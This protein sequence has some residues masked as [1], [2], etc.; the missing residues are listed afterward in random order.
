MSDKQNGRD[1]LHREMTLAEI[2]EGTTGGAE[3]V[4]VVLYVYTIES[5]ES[6]ERSENV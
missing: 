2:S 3:N 5:I 6:I 4:P 1:G